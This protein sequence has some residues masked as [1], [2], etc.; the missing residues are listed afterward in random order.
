MARRTARSTCRCMMPATAILLASS[1]D[2]LVGR[3]R[4]RTWR[5][6]TQPARRAVRDIASS[7]IVFLVLEATDWSAQQFTAQS[8]AFGSLFYTV[9]GFHGVH[10]IVGLLHE[11][12]GADLGLARDRHRRHAIWP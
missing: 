7:A 8:D 9:T 11:H 10:V 5:G 4:N 6:L 12:C 2:L 1:L 3:T